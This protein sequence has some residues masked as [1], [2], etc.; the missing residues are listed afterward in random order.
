MILTSLGN[1]LVFCHKIGADW[2]TRYT[3]LSQMIK[4]GLAVRYRNWYNRIVADQKTRA[5]NVRIPNNRKL[6]LRTQ[7]MPMMHEIFKREDYRLKLEKSLSEAAVVMDLGANIGLASIFF[8]QHYFPNARFVAVEP[9]PKN[10]AVLQQNLANNIEKAEIVP[11]VVSNKNGL[12]L[13]D[14][15]EVGYNVHIIHQKIAQN[16]EGERS[17]EVIALTLP[18]IFEDL[19]IERID[20]LKMDIE[21]AEKEVLQDAAQWISKVQMM[22][23]ELHG[24]Y[25]E[26]HL[27][28][29]IEPYG[30]VVS[31]AHVKHLF[32]AKRALS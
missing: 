2:T 1:A 19:N 10:I 32:L 29:D 12:L 21:G 30:F 11:V 6:Y 18:Q 17:T 22:V 31:K 14:D 28:R 8:Q 23:I 9:S 7:D 27:Q 5:F 16:T 4:R 15:T 3:L 24:D 20:L 26:T 25:T 13:I